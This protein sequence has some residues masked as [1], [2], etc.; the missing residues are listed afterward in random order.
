MKETLIPEREGG[1]GPDGE[2]PGELV[3]LYLQGIWEIQS[4]KRWVALL[5]MD[6]SPAPAASVCL[7]QVRCLFLVL[8]H[9]KSRQQAQGYFTVPRVLLPWR[10]TYLGHD[11]SQAKFNNSKVAARAILCSYIHTVGCNIFAINLML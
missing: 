9:N 2:V 11:E 5:G 4:R 10:T 7:H 6:P 1:R 8:W 3:P